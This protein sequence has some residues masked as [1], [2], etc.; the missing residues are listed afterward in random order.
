MRFTVGAAVAL[1]RL[2]DGVVLAVDRQQVDALLASRAGHEL[3]R[4][5]QHLFVGEG[6]VLAGV[7]GRE[8]RDETERADERREHEVG[9]RDASRRRAVLPIRRGCGR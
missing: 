9:L 4:D 5:H 7:D 3:A 6:D 1:E 2:E 8:R